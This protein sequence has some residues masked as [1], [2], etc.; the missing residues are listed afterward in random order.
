MDI[1]LFIP[2]PGRDHAFME[3][4]REMVKAGG[5]EWGWAHIKLRCEHLQTLF[6][7]KML[8]RVGAE[9]RGVF[10]AGR[11]KRKGEIEAEDGSESKDKD[12]ELVPGADHKEIEE[13]V[14]VTETGSGKED[15]GCVD[16]EMNGYGNDRSDI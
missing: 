8:E 9:E 16:A 12:K 7:I 1:R 4:D 10:G 3:L 5:W 6:V 14:V 15:Q 11:R 2:H 13:A